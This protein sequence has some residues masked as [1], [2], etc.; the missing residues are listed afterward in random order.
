MY[1]IKGNRVGI[2]IVPIVIF[3]GAGV[4]L[5]IS[6]A[7][8]SENSPPVKDAVEDGSNRFL[9]VGILLIGALVGLIYLGKRGSASY[10]WR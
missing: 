8:I 9:L 6:G 4:S 5:G 2:L 7:L 10:R 3:I 1:E